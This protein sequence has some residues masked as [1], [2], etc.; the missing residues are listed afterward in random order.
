MCK[1]LLA[2]DTETT[3]ADFFHGCRP[4]FVSTCTPEG[5]QVSWNWPVDPETRTPI[6]PPG[7]TKQIAG[8][9]KGKRL[10]FHNAKFDIRALATV[11]VDVPALVGWENVE[12]THLASHCLN[13]LTS[14]KL[15]DLALLHLD[16]DDR[17]QQE[18][19]TATTAAR[20]IARKLGW[21]IARKHHLHFPAMKRAPGEGWWVLDTWL[22]EALAKAGHALDPSWATNLATYGNLDTVRTMG[23]WVLF[24]GWIREERLWHQYS[25]R[26]RLLPITYGMEDAGLTYSKARARNLGV[27]FT[28]AINRA[29]THAYRLLPPEVK[30]LAPEGEINFRSVTQLRPILYDHFKLPVFNSGKEGPSTDKDTLVLLSNHTAPTS[31]AHH[32]VNN[33]LTLRQANTALGYLDSYKTA[34]CLIANRPEWG[35]LHSAVNIAGTRSTR[36]SSSNPNSQNISD[37]EEFNLRRAFG[38][39]PGRVWVSIDYANIELRIFAYESGDRRLI[40]AFE[41]GQS[42]HMV[43]ASE[44]WPKEYKALGPK[45]FKKTRKYKWTKN[46]NFALIYGAGKKTADT[47]YRLDGAYERI[48]NRFPLIDRFMATYQAKGR[49]DG[50]ITTLGGYRLYVPKDGPHKAVNYFVQG[51]AGWALMLGMIRCQEYLKRKPGHR[52]IMAVHDELVFDLPRNHHVNQTAGKLGRIMARSEEDIGLPTP[53]NPEIITTSWDKGESLSLT[54]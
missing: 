3:G 21:N 1:L 52:L 16:L 43:I 54:T 4:F 51:S 41:G 50:Y 48:R 8:Y 25:V 46:G 18:L 34:H 38:P 53:V 27:V 23:L 42:V 28:K 19:Q 12:D 9:L 13:S 24:Q 20:R 47:T 15:K 45:Q 44:L 31:R 33:L 14:H 5:R 40:Q 32:F 10:V 17:D 35:L 6:I 39:L 30:A 49:R 22:P 7:D 29:A 36:Q 2:V 11:G 26:K 37:Q